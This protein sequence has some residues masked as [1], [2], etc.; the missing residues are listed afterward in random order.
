MQRIAGVAPAVISIG[1][2]EI[3]VPEDW[4][5]ILKREELGSRVLM[6]G[7]IP[8]SWFAFGTKETNLPAEQFFNFRIRQESAE[9]N[10]FLHKMDLERSLKM[11][12]YLKK[13]VSDSAECKLVEVQ[14]WG[15]EGVNLHC[16]KAQPSEMN[17]VY[18]PSLRVGA[19]ARGDI[20][21]ILGRV[22]PSCFRS[23]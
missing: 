3:C 13:K 6:Y 23:H 7:L 14:T 12:Q 15:A 17:F 2:A 22:S 1:E 10:L 16:L 9:V 4:F 21:K 19:G 20:V 18:F 8:V 5:L 11:R